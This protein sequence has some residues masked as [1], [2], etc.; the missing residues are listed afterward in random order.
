MV[1]ALAP[2]IGD[3]I[4]VSSGETWQRQRRMIDPAFTMMR[5]IG[6]SPPC[7]HGQTL[8]RQ[9]WRVR[10]QREPRSRLILP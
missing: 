9:C 6:P 1:D 4:F 7:R 8:A 5:V 2:L 10:P 3:S